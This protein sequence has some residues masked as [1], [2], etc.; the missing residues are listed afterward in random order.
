MPDL[1]SPAARRGG[2]RAGGRGEAAAREPRG[3]AGGGPRLA[4][5]LA[6]GRWLSSPKVYKGLFCFSD[7][8]SIPLLEPFM[9]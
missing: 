9:L 3:R 7:V 2:H 8:D 1:A 6:S 4:R 5:W